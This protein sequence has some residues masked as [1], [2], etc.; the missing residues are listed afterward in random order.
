MSEYKSMREYGMTEMVFRQWGSRGRARSS[1]ALIDVGALL[2]DGHVGTRDTLFSRRARDR[3]RWN[4]K[5]WS[6]LAVPRRA[7]P[8]RFS[9]LLCTT[10]SSDTTSRL[11]NPRAPAAARGAVRRRSKT[12]ACATPHRELWTHSLFFFFFARTI[13]RRKIRFG[14]LFA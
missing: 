5:Y 1:P 4:R 2:W 9:E 3:R 10:S 8:R 14:K 11:C 6:P 13:L 7:N 12:R